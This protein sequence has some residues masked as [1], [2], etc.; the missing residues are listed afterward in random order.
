MTT[1][2]TVTQEPLTDS[3]NPTVQRFLFEE[4]DGT[5]TEEE[6][7]SPKEYAELRKA[8][9]NLRADEHL[10]KQR[11]QRPQIL[12]RAVFDAFEY[13]NWTELEKDAA[14]ESALRG[15]I[16]RE[17]RRR[18]NDLALSDLFDLAACTEAIQNEHGCST[19]AEG[20][21]TKVANFH[22]W[23][24]LTPADVAYCLEEFRENFES[25]LRDSKLFASRYASLVNDAH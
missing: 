9:R 12:G 3:P 16:L 15:Q 13:P 22:A 5:W 25:E 20:F 24:G 8:L 7:L 14:R 2:T 19:P 1:N 10:M 4:T 17:I 11:R 18:M 6:S 23:H 21:I